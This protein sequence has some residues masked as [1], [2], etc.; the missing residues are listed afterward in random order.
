V[1]HTTTLATPQDATQLARIAIHEVA[2]HFH[3]DRITGL[4][5]L[6]ERLFMRP[7]LR[8]SRLALKFDQA[9]GEGGLF[10]AARQVL[11]AF[12]QGYS[13]AQSAPVPPEGPLLVLANHPG[14][15]DSL[16]MLAAI[17][18]PDLY[19]VTAEH[20]LLSA[21]PHTG[22]HLVMFSNTDVD[23]MGVLKSVLAL[24]RKGKAV[25]LF[26]YG[27]LETDPAINP[28]GGATLQGWSRS[29][30]MFLS[31]VPN[32]CLIL[33]VI[34]GTIS[35]AA[36]NSPL[37]RLSWTKKRRQQRAMLMQMAV[38]PFSGGLPLDDVRVS[39]SAPLV[40]GQLSPTL[41]PASLHRAILNRYR[42]FLNAAR[43]SQS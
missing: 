9:A 20:R 38:H 17:N 14:G 23:R 15:P 8:F 40:P 32:A 25:L 11:P 34:S 36:Y 24:L 2:M 35:K 18:R 1:E 10:H 43:N 27:M 21:L 16:A 41:E 28:D 4:P 37:A 33:G 26:P 39:L 7:A 19:V 13:I 3:L 5:S 6:L 42:Q 30:G 31:R 29:P 22:R 12:I